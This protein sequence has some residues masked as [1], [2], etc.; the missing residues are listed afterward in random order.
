MLHLF[1]KGAIDIT[2]ETEQQLK[3]I[4][5]TF[6]C[7]SPFSSTVI[8]VRALI[9]PSKL[10]KSECSNLKYCVYFF[11]FSIFRTFSQQNIYH[12]CGKV[13]LYVP[14]CLPEFFVSFAEKFQAENEI[15]PLV[16][17]DS[18]FNACSGDFITPCASMKC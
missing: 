12:V 4:T 15:F 2:L 16:S 3:K 10:I 5:K 8:G 7:T 14:V 18:L 9:M 11:Y 17:L 6:Y 13:L 1:N